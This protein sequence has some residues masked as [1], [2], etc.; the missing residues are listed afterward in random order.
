MKFFYSA[1]HVAAFNGSLGTVKYCV[2]VHGCNLSQKDKHGYN[3]IEACAGGKNPI[4]YKELDKLLKNVD[5]AND[6]MGLLYALKDKDLDAVK[7]CVSHGHPNYDQDFNFGGYHPNSGPSVYARAKEYSKKDTSY[8]KFV[9]F[10]DQ[11]RLLKSKKISMSLSSDK[12]DFEGN[13]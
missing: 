7:Y 2:E 3:V 6:E 9:E 4:Y 13:W 8:K 12:L 11:H 1:T 10:F 5:Y